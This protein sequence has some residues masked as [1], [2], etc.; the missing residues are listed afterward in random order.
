MLDLTQA[1]SHILAAIHPLDDEVVALQDALNRIAAETISSPI[2]LPLFDNS[3]MDGYALRA[4]D[5]TNA[6]SHHPVRLRVVGQVSAGTVFTGVVTTGNCVQLFTG[7]PLPVGANAVV[8]QE[9]T[10]QDSL[11]PKSIWVCDC[12]KPWDNVRLRG[13]DVRRGVTLLEKGC[14]L[15]V[16]RIS[17]LA[18][19]GLD[20]LR[21][22][23]RPVV[24]VLATGSEL[25]ESGAELSPGQIYESNR[26]TLA[27]L[28]GKT[29]AK[30]RIYPLI[31]DSLTDTR[32]ALHSALQECDVILT[33][34][35]ISVGG[36]DFVKSAFEQ[37]GG[38]LDFWRVSIKPGKPF[39]FGQFQGRYLFGLPGNP[40]SAFVT[41]LVLVRPALLRLQS[42]TDVELSSRPGILEEPLLN[43]GDRTH[44][45]R[46]RIDDNGLVRSAGAQAS[47]MV[48]PLAK[49]NGLVGV[50]KETCW[51]QGTTVKVLIWD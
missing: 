44:F 23:K 20:L 35:G 46:V 21:V 4:E 1:Q 31:G 22:G 10:R 34:G 38:T 19:A 2:D 9:E 51:E 47:H 17:L 8:M 30:P 41:F 12:P 50:P 11:D 14:P 26:V 37:A 16:G 25:R 49:A 32:V 48:G 27:A 29:G 39:A 42:A 33:S 45:M 15:T 18:A 40:L 3:A 6:S 5:L 43:G 24:G 13:E 36:F 28:L 7:S